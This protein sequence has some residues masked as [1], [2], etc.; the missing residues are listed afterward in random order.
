MKGDIIVLAII[1]MVV[2]VFLMMTKK[3]AAPATQTVVSTHS[4][5]G[6]DGLV[7]SVPPGLLQGLAAL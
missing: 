2:V 1:V 5:T 4:V 6:L 3:A 7:Y